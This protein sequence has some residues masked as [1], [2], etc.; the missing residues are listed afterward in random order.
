MVDLWFTCRR[1]MGM[2]GSFTAL[3]CSGGVGEQPAALMDAFALLDSNIDK[4]AE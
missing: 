4:E 1:N 3:P 2:M